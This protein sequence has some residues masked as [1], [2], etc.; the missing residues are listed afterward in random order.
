MKESMNLK[1][2]KNSNV[3]VAIFIDDLSNLITLEETFYSVSKQTHNVDLLVLHSNTFSDEQINSLKS[4]LDKPKLILRKQNAEGKLEEQ[5]LETDG[6]I[7]YFLTP[8]NSD[9]FPKIFNE[10]FNV[11]SENEYEFFS[12]IEPNDVV[13]LNWYTQANI[14]AKENENV[15]MFFPIIRNTVNG[16]FNGLLNEA[17][18]AEGL[19]EEAG[20]ID[21]NLLNRF[22]CVVPTGS[23][24]KISALKEYSEQRQDGKFYPF[25]ESMKISHYYEFLMR[26]VYNDVKAMCIPRIGYE[27]KVKNNNEF[28]HVYCKIPQNIAQIPAE[29]GGITPNEGKFWMETAKKEYFFDEDRNKV[30]EEAS[31]Q[32]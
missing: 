24:L 21:L 32:N 12:V 22:N 30:Y 25:K 10:G 28:K 16:V 31:Q 1:D 19:A 23:M 15:S 3:L 18:W 29:Q 20:K 5:V 4:A 6:K 14:Y 26:M 11:A 8:S 2:L 13:G 17:P 27:F 7:N 9:S